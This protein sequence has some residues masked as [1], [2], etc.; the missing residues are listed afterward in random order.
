MPSGGVWGVLSIMPRICFA[1]ASAPAGSSA[2]LTP[3]A[4]P[5]PPACTWALT[6]TLPPSLEAIAL[7][8]AGVSATSPF[9]TG[10]PNSR[11]M[12]L[13]W[14]SW[15][16]IGGLALFPARELAHEPDHGIV[17]LGHHPLLERDDGI[18]GDMDVLRA[19]LGAALRDIAKADSGLGPGQLEPVVGVQRVHFELGDPHDEARAGEGRLVL[20]VVADDVA[21]VLAQEALDALPELL[22]PLHVGL[23]H[24]ARAVRLLGTGLEGRDGLGLLEVVRDIRDQ[25]AVEREGL[26]GRDSDGGARLEDIHPRHAHEPRSA[27]DL[28]AARAALARLAVPAA[29]QIARLPGLDPMDHIQHHHP[30]VG[31]HAVVVAGVTA[32]ALLALERAQRH[33]LGHRQHRVKVQRQVPGWVELAPALHLDAAE[34]LL[35]HGD[36][37]E[38]L[39]ELALVADDADQGLHA[40]L[41]IGVDAVRIFAPAGAGERRQQLADPRVGLPGVHGHRALHA[42]DV[43]RGIEPRP[44]TEHDEVGQRVA[45]EP[46]GAVQAS[47]DLAGGEEAGDAGRGRVRVH[48]DPAVHV[49]AGRAHLHHFLRDVHP[50]QLHELVVHG[51]Q[52]LADVRRRT[53]GADIQINTAVGAAAPRLD[54]G[55]DGARDL[56]A[57]KQ[58]GSAPVLLVFV[59]GVGFLLVVGGLVLEVLGDVVK[60]EA[61]AFRVLQRAAVAAHAL[62]HQ[63]AAHAGRPDHAGRVELDALHVDALGPRP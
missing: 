7:A 3:P 58:I 50:R 24:A 63:K 2:S 6:T 14:Y 49:V 1:A 21:D 10:T 9:G 31:G 53:P 57:R 12:A 19:D 22:A 59:P 56:V 18:V 47:G 42:L 23:G 32:A 16:F 11:R 41:Q 61:H 15:I 60:H 25:I 30:L 13:A 36:L 37:L 43:L 5:R 27:I 52:A 54:L 48:P 62:G 45:A 39:L 35:E 44:P 26:H 55:I 29:G 38:R 40:F 4:L 46:V 20:R 51:G 8:C 33:G 34:P 17:G 28:G